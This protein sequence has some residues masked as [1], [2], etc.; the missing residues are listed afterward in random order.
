MGQPG[1]EL[2]LALVYLTLK[3]GVADFFLQRSYQYLN[4]GKYGHPGGLLH[5]GI[6]IVCTLPVFL[7]LPTTAALAT[8]ILVG[9]FIVH[10][11]IDWTKEQVLKARELTPTK[12]AFWWA[13]GVD[14]TAHQ[15][16]YIAIVWVL[17]NN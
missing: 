1:T 15:L 6:H 12:N 7:I 9:E 2:L 3:H 13:L 4:K 17:L 5:S 10:Y 16:T 14:Q 11:H 8:A